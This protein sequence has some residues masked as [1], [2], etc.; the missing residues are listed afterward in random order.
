MQAARE[1]KRNGGSLKYQRI[2]GAIT[3][4]YKG[5]VV[6]YCRVEYSLLPGRIQF[7]A[8]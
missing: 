6:I 8:G 1:R 2:R 7:A 4:F 3:L 5:K